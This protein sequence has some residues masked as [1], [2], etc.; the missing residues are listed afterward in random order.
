MIRGSCVRK[1]FK[2]FQLYTSQMYSVYLTVSLYR[3]V[4]N[5]M[6]V[7]QYSTWMLCTAF[8][9]L[10]LCFSKFQFPFIVT[11]WKRPTNAI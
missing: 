9:I 8:A 4:K 6:S 1:L 3:S 7:L 2:V 5:E 11:S 10:S